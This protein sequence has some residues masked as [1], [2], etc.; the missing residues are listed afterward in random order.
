MIAMMFGACIAAVGCFH[1]LRHAMLAAGTPLGLHDVY[2]LAIIVLGAGIAFN[3][4][5]TSIIRSWRS[6]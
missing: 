1:F 4:E 3:Q 2:P 6:K 5:V